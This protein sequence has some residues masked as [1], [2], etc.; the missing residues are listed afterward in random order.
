MIESDS[1]RLSILTALGAV[2]VSSSA[3]VFHA[4]FEREFAEELGVE[5]KRPILTCRSSDVTRC[6]IK[7]GSR[8]DIEAQSFAVRRIEPDG[9]GMSVLILE[10]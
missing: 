1:D 6:Q 7:K 5:G 8:V 2:P 4:V 10:G 9:S 3:G